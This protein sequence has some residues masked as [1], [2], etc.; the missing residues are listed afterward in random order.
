MKLPRTI[1]VFTMYSPPDETAKWSTMF[2]PLLW[3]ALGLVCVVFTSASRAVAVP[4]DRRSSEPANAESAIASGA[5]VRDTRINSGRIGDRI[6]PRTRAQSSAVS[7]A[8]N[9]AA[10]A[11]RRGFK[12][13][14]RGMQQSAGAG[15]DHGRALLNSQAR[16]RP[17]GQTGRP[18]SNGAATT[19]PTGGPVASKRN[20]M[21]V[22]KPTALT[23]SAP[24][25]GPRVQSIGRL[26]G[27]AVGRTNRSA[28]LDGT[29][30]RRKF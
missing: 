11:P 25:G 10:V 20:V 7:K 28:A 29:Q 9:S 27:P 30:F 21:P 5:R 19:I 26:G 3:A 18:I 14:L 4:D 16:G 12:T 2:S 8:Q 1:E 6:P 23:R 22:T 24:L 17:A 15:A 13:P